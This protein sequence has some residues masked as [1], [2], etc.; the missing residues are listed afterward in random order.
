MELP[1]HWR[2]EELT[3]AEMQVGLGIAALIGLVYCF[4]GYRVF[5]VVL[6]LTGFLLAGAVAAVLSG[7][8]SG[9]H[10]VVMGVCMLLGGLC[11]AMALYW[12]YRVGVFCLGFLGGLAAGYH[13]LSTYPQSWTPLAV[14]GCGLAAGL[15]ALLLERPAMVFA[16]AAVGAS[17]V[18]GAA[19][20]GLASTPLQEWLGSGDYEP[21][22]GW[23]MLGAWAV[24]TLGGT[25]AQ[26]FWGGKKQD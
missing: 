6:A 13:V 4:A 14:A 25:L 5:R 9:G 24:L 7:Y 18:V 19:V 11:G 17:L 8:L 26:L 16:T 23:A 12:L 1:E 20:L 15:L 22:V 2:L 3:A 21:Y 10:L